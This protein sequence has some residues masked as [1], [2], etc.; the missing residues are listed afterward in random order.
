MRFVYLDH[1]AGT[2]VLPEVFEAMKP[3]FTEA[4]GNASSLHQ[5]GLRAR[6]AMA[7]AR[8][9][10]ADFLGVD[11]PEEIIF[12]ADGTEAANLAIKGVAYANQRKGNHL[13]VSEIEHPAVLNSIEFLEKQG[14]TC[15]R[16]K[17]DSQGRIN[18]EDVRVALT[19][20]TILIAVHHVNHDIGTIEPVA[21]I[22]AIAAERGI[23]FYVD[24]EASAGWLP[25]N[26]KELGASLLSFSAHRLYGPKGAGVLYR[27]RK[28]RMVGI[29]HGGV[30]ENGRRAGLENI[31]A[32][33][34]CGM[35][36][37]IAKR[38]LS[39]R[40]AHTAHL[41][42]R[43]WEGLRSRIDYIR[44]NGP[45]LGPERISTN[46]NLSTEFIEGEGQLL[47]CDVNGIAVASGSSCVSKSLKISHVLAAIGLDHA[48]AQGNV[49]MSLGKDNS[50]E[51]IDYV[52]ETFAKVVATLR[53]MSPMW[54]EF[55]KGLID[56]VIQPR[57]RGKSFGEHASDMAGKRAS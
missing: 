2:L 15:T 49:I 10:V 45:E 25:V 50:D 39:Q 33:V 3:Y 24:A 31:P 16:V 26:V 1:Q 14:F 27:S 34:G 19:D 18:P 5:H 55:E 54:D 44:L 51:D 53:G 9:Q 11:S 41:Q 48:L 46:L 36:V 43:L 56:S 37:E 38:D 20:K 40:I 23:P 52:I 32:I 17:V 47:R 29:T 30:Q 42:R 6:D 35:A 28:A 57:G 12:T 22:G 21:A 7:K 13:V 4:F 8:A